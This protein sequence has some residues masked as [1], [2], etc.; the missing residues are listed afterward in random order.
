MSQSSERPERRVLL[1]SKPVH[2][3][4]HDGSQVLVR[5]I[6]NHARKFTPT[7]MGTGERHGFAPHVVVERT[8]ARRGGFA[9]GLAQNVRP[10]WRLLVGAD[11][12]VWHFVFAP[13][14]RSCS[15]VRAL[16]QWKSRP[17]VQTIA[18]P[19]RSFDRVDDLLFGDAVVAQSR[20]TA[21]QVRQ[22]SGKSRVVEVIRPPVGVVGTPAPEVVASLRRQLEIG[23]EDDVVTYPGDLEFSGGAQ[24]VRDLVQPLLE[25]HPRALVVFAC[26]QKTAAAADAQRALQTQLD[27]ARVRF[28]GELPSLPV[29]LAASK[30]VVFPVADLFA[31]V[32]IPIALL[33]AMS[34]GV[35]LVVPDQGPV[36]ELE[37]AVRVPLQDNVAW[38]RACS[39]LLAPGPMWETIRTRQ[40]VQL[41]SE[42]AAKVVAGRYED[43][44]QRVLGKAEPGPKG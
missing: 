7:V 5:E 38:V 12:D 32:D 30:L 9:P 31:K 15:V 6:A 11:A 42:F 20:W 43:L 17:S 22:H 27:P 36:A 4:F 23:A 33:E 1:V 13:N 8:Y 44:Y 26:R 16:R 24:R 39:E 14:Q 2:A 18:S 41:E 21:E 10:L 3:P 25:A 37:S 29:L 28:A 19:P 34:L 40:R 35:P